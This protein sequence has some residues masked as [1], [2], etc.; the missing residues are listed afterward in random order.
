MGILVPGIT[1]TQ[2]AAV[3]VSPPSTVVYRLTTPM[4]KGDKVREIQQRLKATDCSPGTIDGIY[5][6]NTQ[7]A[8]VAFQRMHDLVSDGEVGV[9]TATA[10]GVQ[11]ETA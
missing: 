1:Y 3:I 7:A 6:P 5:G 11:L 9:Q 8:V 2:G 4:M 10:L